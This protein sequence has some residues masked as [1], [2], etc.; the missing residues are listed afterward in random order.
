MPNPYDFDSDID[1]WAACN[2]HE[3]GYD[4]LTGNDGLFERFVKAHIE[5][6]N[7][8]LWNKTD[9]MPAAL[10]F[11][12]T[13]RFEYNPMLLHGWNAILDASG[14]LEADLA[15]IDSAPALE[16]L[17]FSK[18]NN[19]PKQVARTIEDIRNDLFDELAHKRLLLDEY[20]GEKEND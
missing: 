7:E 18:L 8:K 12:H 16:I 11:L 6:A 15:A 20:I 1:Y 10:H 2:P 17:L 5:R 19:F 9:L 4:A 3:A 13:L 14:D